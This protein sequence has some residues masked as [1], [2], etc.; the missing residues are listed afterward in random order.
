MNFEDHFSKLAGTYSKYRPYYPS[1]LYEYLASCCNNHELAWDC[2]TGNGQAA[3]E[4]AGY[5]DKVYATDASKEQIGNAEKHAKIIYSIEPA[6]KVSLRTSSA[7]LVTVAVAVHWFDFDKFYSEVNRILK[8][9]GIIAVW[10]YHLPIISSGVD[11][12]LKKY[13]KENL[14]GYWPERFHYLDECY[15]TLPFPFNELTPPEFKIKVKWNLDQLAGFLSS[16]SGTK[17]Y[18]EAT[19]HSPILDIWDDLNDAWGEENHKHSI[20]WLLHM[21]IGKISQTD[22]SLNFN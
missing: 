13:Y 6:G 9:G 18:V 3:I 2:G 4:L 22:F 11:S 12:V 8:P 20:E 15:R 19:G 1:T 10:A 7:D 21:R 5:F 16:W 17:N 14:K